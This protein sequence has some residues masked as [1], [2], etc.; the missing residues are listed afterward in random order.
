MSR[1]V[2]NIIIGYVVYI[3]YFDVLEIDWDLIPCGFKFYAY[4]LDNVVV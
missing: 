4:L 3:L 2:S 1:N